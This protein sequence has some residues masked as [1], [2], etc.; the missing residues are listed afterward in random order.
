MR[1]RTTGTAYQQMEQCRRQRHGYRTWRCRFIAD[2]MIIM[3]TSAIVQ[4]RSLNIVTQSP[5]IL[6]TDAA[7]ATISLQRR[8]R[9]RLCTADKSRPRAMSWVSSV[10]C[11]SG[12]TRRSVSA[13]DKLLAG[14][15]YFVA[16]DDGHLKGFHAV[17]KWI[18]CGA[19]VNVLILFGLR[20]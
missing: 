5:R 2:S 4:P 16:C 20:A 3:S 8:R 19:E 7:A 10:K 11:S 13:T 1:V 6:S 14:S 9:K 18:W 15:Y 17:A 12:G